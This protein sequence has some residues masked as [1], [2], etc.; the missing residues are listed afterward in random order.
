MVTHPHEVRAVGLAFTF[1]FSV[2]FIISLWLSGSSCSLLTR[3]P[4]VL[5]NWISYSLN[6]SGTFSFV[7]YH[8]RRYFIIMIVAVVVTCSPSGAP[9]THVIHNFSRTNVGTTVSKSFSP[10]N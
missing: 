5:T 2:S 6:F 9:W 7:S 4:A 8:R 3:R 1:F 10:E